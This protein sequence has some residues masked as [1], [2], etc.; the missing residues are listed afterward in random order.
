[1]SQDT[2]KAE[3]P[4]PAGIQQST[5]S[6]QLAVANDSFPEVDLAQWFGANHISAPPQNVVHRNNTA[7]HVSSLNDNSTYLETVECEVCLSPLTSNSSISLTCG[8]TWCQDCLNSNVRL[9]LINRQDFPPRCCN[10][11]LVRVLISPPFNPALI[12][13]LCSE[14]Q[15]ALYRLELDWLD[16]NDSNF[17]VGID[18]LR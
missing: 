1:M 12:S 8:H 5:E 11:V 4:H 10:S 18:R 9:S 15:K 14:D 2:V 17:N 6:D 7:H 16:A 3:S 13:I